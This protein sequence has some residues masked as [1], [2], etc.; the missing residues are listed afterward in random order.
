M[1]LDSSISGKW[2]CHRASGQSQRILGPLS[3]FEDP[4]GTSRQRTPGAVPPHTCQYE[5]LLPGLFSLVSMS[6]S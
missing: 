6:V 4:V 1:R 3:M 2:L 5:G